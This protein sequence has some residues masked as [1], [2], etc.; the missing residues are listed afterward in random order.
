[1]K[2]QGVERNLL[3]SPEKCMW[4]DGRRAEQ[5]ATPGPGWLLRINDVE[6]GY[7]RN[8]TQLS[9]GAVFFHE[10]LTCMETKLDLQSVSDMLGLEELDI[11]SVSSVAFYYDGEFGHIES[12]SINE[13]QV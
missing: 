11:T 4:L 8:A 12:E 9:Q 13:G 3:M 2:I 7:V 1:M 10:F 6:F 5:G